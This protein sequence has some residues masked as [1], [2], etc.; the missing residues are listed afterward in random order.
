MPCEQR[1]PY[2][3]TSSLNLSNRSGKLS[4]LMST[5][6]TSSSS[7]F[8]QLWL[9]CMTGQAGVPGV[10][11]LKGIIMKFKR[12]CPQRCWMFAAFESDSSDTNTLVLPQQL[13]QQSPLAFHTNSLVIIPMLS[14]RSE[15]FRTTFVEMKQNLH[16]S[17]GFKGSTHSA[18]YN[19]R[20]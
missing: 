5:R 2:L 14:V 18:G 16:I 6:P 7:S 8:T 9:D 13:P 17:R 10:G 15:W 4:P 19:C 3:M 11:Q 20:L 12:Y 1:L